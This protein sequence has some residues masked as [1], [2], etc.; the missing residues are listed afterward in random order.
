MSKFNQVDL[1]FSDIGDLEV[2]RSGDLKDTKNSYGKAVLQEVRD[3]LRGNFGDWKLTPQ[4]GANVKEFLGESG[5]QANINRIVE[6][7]IEAITF[8]GLLDQASV[9]I[10]PLQIGDSTVLFRIIVV[11]REGELTS[12]FS[13][14]T[15]ENR[16]IGY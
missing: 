5:T 3:R 2:D 7:V 9:D 12:T 6:R 15:N 4:L 16:F 8:D 11:T 13:F 14:D 10:I 1:W